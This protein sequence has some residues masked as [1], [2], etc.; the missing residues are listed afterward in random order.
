[1]MEPAGPGAVTPRAF[2]R[3]GGATL[4]RHQLGLALAMDCQRIVCLARDVA[5]ELLALQHQAEGAGARFHILSSA[6]ALAGLVTA[7][8]DLL[9]LS[10]GLL[11]DPGEARMLLE[12]GHAVLVQPIETGLAAGF[13]RIDINHAAA[14]AFRVPGRLVEQLVELPPD[15]DVPS[16]L[17]RIALQAGVPMQQVPAP[18]R[19]GVRWRLIRDEAE[20]HAIE[21]DWMREHMGERSARTPVSLLSR[22]ALLTLGP[23]LLHNGNGSKGGDIATLV[24]I[25]L[26]LGAGWF[27]FT[28]VGFLLCAL[29][30]ILRD[31]AAMLQRVE[32]ASLSLPAP[33]LSVEDA[34]GWLLDL[35]LV[36]L[37]VWAAPLMPWEAFVG[38]LFP[39]LMLVILA[40][41]LPRVFDRALVPWIEDRVLLALLLALAAGLGAL[42]GAV[43]VLALLLA[44]AGLLF[45]GG[46]LRLT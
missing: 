8:D 21:I 36:L 14:G 4:A 1:M 31:G 11:A 3:V 38:R 7:N 22:F 24:T 20:A 44:I 16:A 15:C 34:L 13:E 26:G 17:T 41:L 18:A 12:P 37:V 9:V 39:P 27:G 28:V 43:Q 29:A 30:A 40:R 46:K 2:L 23:S 19:E 33:S 42:S 25:L 5:P 35:A 45:P 6:R 32:R 10:D